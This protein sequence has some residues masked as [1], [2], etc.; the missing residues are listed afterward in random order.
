MRV[1][2]QASGMKVSDGV[3]GTIGTATQDNRP[4]IYFYF[5]SSPILPST[6]IDIFRGEYLLHFKFIRS[7]LIRFA[8]ASI[9]ATSLENA[10]ASRACLS[11]CLSR[12]HGAYCN[13]RRKIQKSAD[14]ET[15]NAIGLDNDGPQDA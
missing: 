3:R 1:S 5:C 8:Y 9:A 2:G 15:I 13:R 7:T 14:A 4:L 6:H 11:S 10:W 12:T